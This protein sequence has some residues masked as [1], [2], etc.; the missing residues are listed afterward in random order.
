MKQRYP[1]N[2]RPEIDR[3]V[4]SE[5][6][7]LVQKV[8]AFYAEYE[9]TKATRAIS[10]FVQDHLSNWYVRLCRRRFWKGEY[11]Q[12]KISAYQTFIHL[13]AYCS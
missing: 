2:E 3:W 11:E 7:T 9:P 8:D 13:Y 1:L 10:D 6:N 4:L 5:L 12:D